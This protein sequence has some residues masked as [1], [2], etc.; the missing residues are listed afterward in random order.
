ML[1]GVDFEKRKEDGTCYDQVKKSLRKYQSRDMFTAGKD[2]RLHVKE[3]SSYLADPQMRKCADALL[4]EGW[5]PPA[6]SSS[7]DGASN[8]RMN[9]PNYKGKKNRLDSNGNVMKCFHCQSEYHL[10]F[11]CDEKEKNNQPVE[12]KSMKGNNKPKKQVEQT[13]LSSLLSSSSSPSLRKYVMVCETQSCTGLKSGYTLSDLLAA[14][15]DRSSVTNSSSGLQNGETV[16]VRQPRTVSQLLQSCAAV[17][18]ENIGSPSVTYDE[19]SASS[20]TYL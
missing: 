4:S 20:V 7:V 1:T 18:K 13:M 16:S 9:S 12:K 10:A 6:Q 2:G 5:T 17:D 14:S 15:V 3:E 8:V 11:D 19:Y